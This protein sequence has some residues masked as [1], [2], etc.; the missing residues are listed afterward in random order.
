MSWKDW[1]RVAALAWVLVS[2]IWLAQTYLAS[3]AIGLASMD[4]VAFGNDFIDFW[5]APRLA[6]LG[7]VAD[8]Y[9]FSKFHVFQLATID[10]PIHLY[11]YDYPPIMILLNLPF[12]LLPYLWSLGVWFFGGLLLFGLAVRAAWPRAMPRWGDVA[13]YTLA[14][15]ATYANALSG[16]NGAW[17]AA[18]FGGGLML[19]E[20]RPILGGALLGMLVAKPQM[21]FLIPVALLCWRRWSAL[22]AFSVT[23]AV[24][25]LVTVPL[26]GIDAWWAFANRVDILRRLVLEDDT[27]FWYIFISV[28]VAVR[29]LP[30]PLPLAYAAQAAASVMT[31]VLAIH[32][33]RSSGPQSAKNAVLVIGTFL[34]T[35][36]VQCYDLFVAMLVPLW[37]V[38]SFPADDIRRRECLTASIPLIAAPIFAYVFAKMTGFGI[39]WLMLL[40]A[41]AVALQ[42]CLPV[43]RPGRTS[44]IP[45][46]SAAG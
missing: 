46:L 37:L 19:M 33:W 34:M 21:A 24:L 18:I 30:A 42:A 10:G 22:I 36:Y 14:V 31:L 27:K 6:L 15:P 38:S 41:F 4:R 17:I 43:A 2:S 11:H 40:P 5:A 25:I 28:F 12:A 29:Q 3:T 44:A 7:R 23:A 32:A 13:L 35:P 20:R 9:N 8:V 45:V 16:Q 1:V 26:F 39:G